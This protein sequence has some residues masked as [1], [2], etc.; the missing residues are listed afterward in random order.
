MPLT[1][2]CTDCGENPEYTCHLHSFPDAPWLCRNCTDKRVKA[3]YQEIA[4]L[5]EQ[6]EIY[7]EKEAGASW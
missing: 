2:A 6:V 3:L 5:K 7:V 1:V 4:E